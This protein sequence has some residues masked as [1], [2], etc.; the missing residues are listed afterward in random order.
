[1][2]HWSLSFD[3]QR[4]GRLGEVRVVGVVDVEEVV[5]QPDEVRRSAAPLWTVH[6]FGET[7]S[8]PERASVPR[9]AA[10]NLRLGSGEGG[11]A[12]NAGT[13][14]RARTRRRGGTYTRETQRH[15]RAK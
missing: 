4:S 1:M 2:S 6:T 8:L 3:A 9:Q 7:N 15:T 5:E 12:I 11:A 13:R 14:Q 10:T